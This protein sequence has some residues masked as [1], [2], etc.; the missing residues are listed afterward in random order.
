[1][2]QLREEIMLGRF[3]IGALTFVAGLCAALAPARAADEGKYPDFAGQWRKPNGVT[4]QWDQT[5]PLGLAQQ[6]PLKPEFQASLEASLK[7]QSLGGQGE[8][9]RYTCL[10]NG[11]PRIMTVVWPIE[12]VITPR[13]TYVLFENNLPR[14]IFTDGRAWPT[15]EEPSFNGY[16][17]GKWI[18][19][20][21]SG[22]YDTLEVET[23]KLKG[24]RTFEA[25]GIPMHSDNETVVNERIYV[26]AQDHNVLHNDITT[27][28][29]AL[30]RPWTVNKRYLR[31]RDENVIFYEN[32]CSE[33]NQHVIIG[34]EGY[35]LSADG[36]LM[37]VKKGQKPPDLRY[38][39]ET[40]K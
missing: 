23:R 27:Q 24:P 25:S 31:V 32:E 5:K 28:D 6:A 39:K 12:I 29:H 8:D 16:S 19:S 11:M 20:S 21:G 15:N 38:F 9:A 3:A 35:Y 2:Q 36:Y 4:V 7:D 14:R 40:Q 18:D 34:K 13:I 33:N 26:D 1:L 30:T 37:P 10:P 22:R 17:I